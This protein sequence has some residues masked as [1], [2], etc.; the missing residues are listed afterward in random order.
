MVGNF[1]VHTISMN[2]DAV[3]IP[4][5]KHSLVLLCRSSQS[6]LRMST[7]VRLKFFV[8]KT[9]HLHKRDEYYYDG[10]DTFVCSLPSERGNNHWTLISAHWS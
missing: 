9:R 8:G 4:N 10:D 1:P 5:M 2:F 6:F 7:E 3:G